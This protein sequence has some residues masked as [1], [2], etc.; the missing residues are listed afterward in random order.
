MAAGTVGV[1]VGLGCW[2]WDGSQF[3]LL[4]L[5]GGIGTEGRG[6]CPGGVG[7]EAAAAKGDRGVTWAGVRGRPLVRG[8]KLGISCL[9]LLVFKAIDLASFSLICV[10]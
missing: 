5:L 2:F 3:M 4:W 8:T 7:A 6:V 9:A 1:L 10:A